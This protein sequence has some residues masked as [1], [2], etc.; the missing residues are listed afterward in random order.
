[1]ES[2]IILSQLKEL[3]LFGMAEAF[4]DMA[5]MPVQMRPSL[6]GAV[7]RMI[8]TE[9]RMR[10]DK[11][12]EKL[13]KASKLK[14]NVFVSD[15]SCGAARNLTQDTL[16]KLADCGFM[17]RGENLV[18]T[19][20]TGTGKTYLACALGNQACM[21]GIKTLYLNMNR[22][23]DVIK[24]ARLDGTFNKLINRLDKKD[25]LI[26]DDFGLQ[27]IDQETR[28]G[29]LTLLEERYE[30]KSMIIV[31]QLKIDKWYDYLRDPT[32][33][34]AIMDRIIGTSHQVHLTGDSMRKRKT[35][36]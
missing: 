22:F 9:R 26:L 32:L 1:M 35:K 3:K 36:L 18:I 14:C 31:S 30:K 12:A 34:D 29:L 15:I 13:R 8:E 10:D 28:L 19:G 5:A 17:R 16:T 7:A 4:G 24:Q 20:R 11:L 6:E 25:L 21:V 23:S 2:N 33:A 27:P